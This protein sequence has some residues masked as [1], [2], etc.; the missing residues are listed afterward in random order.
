MEK[1][2]TNLIIIRYLHNHMICVAQVI[3]LHTRI[4]TYDTNALA[5]ESLR[6]LMSN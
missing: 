3:Y 5:I 4:S 1:T 2:Q 6:A